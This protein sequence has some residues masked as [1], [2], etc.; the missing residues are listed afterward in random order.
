MGGPPL[1]LGRQVGAC[2]GKGRKAQKGKERASAATGSPNIYVGEYP[3]PP[4]L[5][6]KEATEQGKG[7]TEFDASNRRRMICL[8]CHASSAVRNLV[9]CLSLAQ[10]GSSCLARLP[11]AYVARCAPRLT[12]ESTWRP[13][14][15]VCSG[16]ALVELPAE[17]CATLSTATRIVLSKK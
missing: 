13:A 2:R 9:H 17:V 3:D 1:A 5:K 12:Q 15:P 16:L 6:S 10:H 14:L 4:Q 8:V 7:T 11:G